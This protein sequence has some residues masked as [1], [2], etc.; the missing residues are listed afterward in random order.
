LGETVRETSAPKS[1]VRIGLRARLL[2]FLAGATMLL[3]S[4]VSY[5]RYHDYPL[6]RGEVAFIVAGFLI[7]SAIM[8]EAYVRLNAWG[9]AVLLGLLFLMAFDINGDNLILALGFGIIASGIGLIRPLDTLRFATFVSSFVLLTSLVGFAH[10]RPPT[11]TVKRAPAAVRNESLPLVVHLILDEH[12]GLVGLEQS[13]GET[14]IAHEISERYR[15]MGFRIYRGAFSRSF[16]TSNAVPTILSLGNM[17]PSPKTSVAGRR[18]LA[19]FEA[20]D[21]MGFRTN[22]IQSTYYNL[23]AKARYDSCRT[24]WHASL[25]SVSGAKLTRADKAWIIAYNFIGLSQIA[26]RLCGF[27][28]NHLSQVLGRFMPVHE[29]L[30]DQ[31]HDLNSINSEAALT[32]MTRQLAMGRPGEVYFG[33]FLI[34]HHPYA[35]DEECALRPA[36]AWRIYHSNRSLADRD[37]SYEQQVECVTKHISLILDA[38]MRSPAGANSVV[39]VQGDHGSRIVDREPYADTAGTLSDEELA[40]S[41]STLFAVKLPNQ[42]GGVVDVQAPVSALLRELASNHF[43]AAPNPRNRPA[44]FWVNLE[45]RNWTPVARTTLPQWSPASEQ[46]QEAS[47]P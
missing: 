30:L 6:W 23:C 27:F 24:Y 33:H 45:N 25:R 12:A 29:I 17:E 40:R 20:L 42:A 22:L 8:A 18:R 41:F 37:R 46:R 43:Q 11:T 2:P 26:V 16:H 47:S 32:Q 36:G 4:F 21:L 1:A 9:R 14:R 10:A 15:S 5:L 31:V 44:E 28:D 39:I 19:Y 3:A 13:R 35:F 34:P 7:I 38:V